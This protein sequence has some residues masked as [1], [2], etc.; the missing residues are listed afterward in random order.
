MP[1]ITGKA[2]AQKRIRDLSGPELIDRVGKALFAGGQ[3]IKA[4]ASFLITQG[5]VSGA[6]HVPSL[7]GQPPNEDTGFLRI[8]INVTQQAP[9]RV[10]ISSDAPYSGFLEFGTSRMEPRPFMQP[11]LAKVKPEII[12]TVRKAAG[13]E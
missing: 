6:N 11:A 4:E 8:N 5:A 12:A 2:K 13:V 3:A 1:K 9:L 7:P 10:R